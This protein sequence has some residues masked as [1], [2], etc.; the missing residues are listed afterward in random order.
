MIRD[1][2]TFWPL[3]AVPEDLMLNLLVK[4][5]GGSGSCLRMLVV[6][7][8]PTFGHIRNERD[9]GCT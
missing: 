2:V 8:N 4:G 3:D 1:R 7:Y 6:L 9:P 5:K